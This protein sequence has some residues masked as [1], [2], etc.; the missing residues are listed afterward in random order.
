MKKK[1]YGLVQVDKTMEMYL[2]LRAKAKK[3]RTK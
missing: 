3:E 1:K 2:R